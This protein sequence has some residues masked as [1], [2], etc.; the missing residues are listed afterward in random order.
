M[1]YH[2]RP[3]NLFLSAE[4]PTQVLLHAG[5]LQPLNYTPSSQ[6]LTTTV[7]SCTFV[8]FHKQIHKSW[9]AGLWVNTSSSSAQFNKPIAKQLIH[10]IFLFVSILLGHTSTSPICS[11]SDDFST[12]TLCF[13]DKVSLRSPACLGTHYVDQT[14]FQTMLAESSCLF[15][16]A[17]PHLTTITTLSSRPLGT[18]LLLLNLV[19]LQEWVFQL[20]QAVNA[21]NPQHLGG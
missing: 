5:S 17:Q 14:S 18:P 12:L 2:T 13:W 6:S 21:C 11:P 9:N 7:P 20:G 8:S 4:A 15:L 1:H 16:Y 19:I 3:F 10:C